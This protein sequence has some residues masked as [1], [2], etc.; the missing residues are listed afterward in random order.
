[1]QVPKISEE[2]ITESSIVTLLSDDTDRNAE[3][4]SAPLEVGASKISDLMSSLCR[5][6]SAPEKKV[7]KTASP[8]RQKSGIQRRAIDKQREQLVES[9]LLIAK[10]LERRNKLKEQRS[11]LFAYGK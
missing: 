5:A 1:M 6:V 7:E 9:V 11:A 4:P 10:S 3:V 2:G 8:H